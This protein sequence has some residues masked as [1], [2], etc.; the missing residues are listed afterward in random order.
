MNTYN[1]KLVHHCVDFCLKRLLCK[2]EI[3]NNC[4]GHGMQAEGNKDE[5][6]EESDKS[7]SEVNDEDDEDGSGEV[8]MII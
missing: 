7:R 2:I 3:A 5:E 6:E 1:K 4:V 8:Y